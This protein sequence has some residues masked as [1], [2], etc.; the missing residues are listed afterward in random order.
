MATDVLRFV[1][2]FPCGCLARRLFRQ[3]E[4]QAVIEILV[5]GRRELGPPLAAHILDAQAKEKGAPRG[6][7]D[8]RI[9]MGKA[10]FSL[11]AHVQSQ[12]KP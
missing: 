9:Q 2:A 1:I 10:R 7:G 6:R 4:Q 5:L 12:C 3:K 8:Q 11:E